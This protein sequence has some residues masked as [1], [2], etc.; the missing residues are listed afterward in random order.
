MAVLANEH[1]KVVEWRYDQIVRRGA[2]REEAILLAERTDVDLHRV[3]DMLA[4]GCPAVWVI[5][6]LL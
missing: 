3:L 1:G 4:A 2:T 6:I 5:E